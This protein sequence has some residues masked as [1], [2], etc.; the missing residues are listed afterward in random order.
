MLQTRGQSIR[1]GQVCDDCTHGM[2]FTPASRADRKVR[3]LPLSLL[4]AP[5]SVFPLPPTC[6]LCPSVPS[7]CRQQDH[8]GTLPTSATSF[9]RQGTNLLLCLWSCDKSN[10]K[11]HNAGPVYTLMD[12]ASLCAD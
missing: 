7:A 3:R 12:A 11:G 9:V 4:L 10:P 8:I 1:C 5:T 6:A 2:H